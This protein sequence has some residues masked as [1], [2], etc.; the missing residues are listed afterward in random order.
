MGWKRLVEATK[1]WASLKSE[2][3]WKYSDES[4]AIN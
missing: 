4:G 3:F 2:R 1:K